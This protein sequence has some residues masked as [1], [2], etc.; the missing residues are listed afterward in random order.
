M[1]RSLPNETP[2]DD[3]LG[4]TPR[5]A[6]ERLHRLA[7]R[8]ARCE[9]GAADLVQETLLIDLERSDTSRR[10]RAAWLGQVCLNV[11]RGQ[12]RR[13]K[14]RRPSELEAARFDAAPSAAE[15][16]ARLDLRHLLAQAV[17]RLSPTQR[18]A[19]VRRFFEGK[20]PT[21]IAREQ[22]TPLATIKRRL[23]RGL[24]ALRRDLGRTRMQWIPLL[25]ASGWGTGRG[26]GVASTKASAATATAKVTY[27]LVA[28]VVVVFGVI[29]WETRDGT[30]SRLDD[31]PHLVGEARPAPRQVDEPVSAASDV[32]TDE[33]TAPVDAFAR[34]DRER[35]LFGIIRD[36]SGR[37]VGGAVVE[38]FADVPTIPP[39]ISSWRMGGESPSFA[40]RLG[41]TATDANGRF[42]I[43]H[44][45]REIIAL[46]VTA[47]DFATR[48][49]PWLC[50]GARCDVVLCRPVSMTVIVESTDGLRLKGARVLYRRGDPDGTGE[51]THTRYEG[52]TD[53]SG[54]RIID[55]LDA[56][57]GRLRVEHPQFAASSER[58]VRTFDDRANQFVFRLTRSLRLRGRVV[59]ADTKR[60]I[61]NAVVGQGHPQVRCDDEGRFELG[62]WCDAAR[63]MA[64]ER[65]GN[66]RR[67]HFTARAPGCVFNEFAVPSIKRVI[68][69]GLRRGRSLSGRIVDSEGRPIFGAAVILRGMNL[70]DLA[71]ETAVFT[72]RHC[73]ETTT[74][75]DGAYRFDAF[76]Y[77]SY[78]WLEVRAAEYGRAVEWCAVL[79][80]VDEMKPVVHP[81]IVMRRGSSIEGRV[82]TAG[83]EPIA[84]VRV[85][86]CRWE[87]P[88]VTSSAKTD[89]LGRFVFAGL[90]GGRYRVSSLGTTIV[91]ATRVS[92]GVDERKTGVELHALGRESW[93]VRAEDDRR[94]PVADLLVAVQPR[95]DGADVSAAVGRTGVDG[96]VV[97]QGLRAGVHVLVL[98][99]LDPGQAIARPRPMEA[100]IG[101][102][103]TTTYLVERL[104][105]LAGQVLVG[106]RPCAD[107]T[108]RVRASHDEGADICVMHT[109][110]DGRF[111]CAVSTAKAMTVVAEVGRVVDDRRAAY[112]GVETGIAV[113][114]KDVVLH[115]S[116]V[117]HEAALSVRVMSPDGRLASDVQVELRLSDGDKRRQK[118][119]D[120]GCVEFEDLPAGFRARVLARSRT[121][122]DEFDRVTI[123]DNLDEQEITMRLRPAV[124]IEGRVVGP[125]RRPKVGWVVT[126]RG[127]GSVEATTD[128]DGRFRLPARPN[129]A[130]DVDTF[131]PT[132][133]TRRRVRRGGVRAGKPL[134]ITVG[135]S[136]D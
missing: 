52:T 37:A 65:Y 19:I 83:G 34:I 69:V 70:R 20:T 136:D 100:T 90:P 53:E 58:I 91:A 135:W 82:V 11:F 26:V 25:A 77:E 43:E 122:R 109:D 54:R 38:T 15:D 87:K 98:G 123:V 5:D 24:E 85:L 14:L 121:G 68:E 59:D 108:V 13:E 23:E 89:D 102:G 133:R 72:E 2:S 36:E 114:R 62:D 51:P 8:L 127:R 61:P 21:E 134:T 86:A 7:A 107:A 60:P 6:D 63:T 95:V 55:V 41:R 128:D 16:A 129:E 116:R 74:D 119:D 9:E 49:I 47:D 39:Q 66:V 73:A 105:M 4:A 80:G 96:R 30:A 88:I 99:K 131:A 33:T 40:R 42:V 118:T 79:K 120:E 132:D 93:T 56:G 101:G 110:A 3:D 106:D 115:A 27:V 124:W 78:H 81:D 22:D 31:S 35:D 12:A 67:F 76:H 112:R 64:V 17:E 92:V 71:R 32:V 111:Q 18:D 57:T 44:R 10:N 126:A 94:R 48:E 130:Y 103:E 97:F 50:V 113:P 28:L 104:G 117:D 46:R 84:G 125:H 75:A 45:R 29:W 1:T